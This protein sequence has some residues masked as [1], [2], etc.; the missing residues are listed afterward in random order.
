MRTD[1]GL[2]A[3]G[4]L[5]RE[6]VR[7]QAAEMF[8]H[9]VDAGQVARSLRVSTKPVYQWRRA[10]RVGGKAVLASKG[11]GGNPCKLNEEQLAQLQAA[12]DDG[13]AAYGWEQDQRWT[14]AGVTTLVTVTRRQRSS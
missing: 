11:A 2:T 8:A 1:G 13:L 12:P 7:L 4:R 6:Q 5:R 9:D 10:W 14:L 3:Q